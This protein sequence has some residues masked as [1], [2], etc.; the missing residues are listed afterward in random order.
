[1][2]LQEAAQAAIDV[3]SACNLS[4]VIHSFAEV[5]NVL[6]DEANKLG[7]GTEWVNRHPICRLFVEQIMY[8]TGEFDYYKAS[9]ICAKIAKGE[10]VSI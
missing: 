5:M 6:W 8:L 10:D 9:D 1:M 2:T 3:Q 7:E 4:G